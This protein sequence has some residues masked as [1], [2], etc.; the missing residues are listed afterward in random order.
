[1][2][3]FFPSILSWLPVLLT[4]LCMI[5]SA[6]GAQWNRVAY[7]DAGIAEKEPHLISGSDWRFENPGD[8]DETARTAVF[9]GRVEFGYVG[10]NPRA[11]YKVKLRFFSDG[12][13][14][15]R[16]KAGEAV[17]LDS[18]A[19]E[20]G[21]VVEREAELPPAAYAGG[22]VTL[23][24]ETVRGPNAVISAIEILST[25]SSALKAVAMP[26]APL[27]LLT[28]RPA[29]APLELSGTWKFS[30]VATEGFEKSPPPDSW[31]NIAVPG[32]WVVQGFHVKPET[33]AAYS[34]AFTLAE[35]PA[36]QRFKL[37]F[38]AVYSLC[39][40]WINGVEVGRH[41]GGFV[42]FEFDVTDAIRAG[43]NTLAVSVQS[44]SL[45]DQLSCASQY[46]CHPLGGISRKVQLFSL[47]QVHIS[48]LKIETTFGEKFRDVTLTAKLA[49][50]N[51]SASV[52]AGSATVA[53]V[54]LDVSTP[55]DAAPVAVKWDRLA[56]G[57]TLAE[58]VQ[59]AVK[60]PSKWDNEH[61]RLYKLVV[62]LRS[63]AGSDEVVEQTFGFRQIEVRG[64]RVLLNGTPIK[65][66]GV[67]RHEVHPLLGR[68]LTPELWRKDAEIF[69]E[70]NCNFIRTS[71]Y[72]P[73]EEF[74]DQCDRLGLLVELEAP[75]C[76]VGHGA[77]DHFK[78]SPSSDAIFQRL[79]L[80]NLETVQGYPN[81]PSVIMRSLA[82]ESTWSP[83]FARVHRA[84][85]KADATRPCTFHDQCWGDANNGGSRQ[86]P[87]AVIHYPGFEGP[88]RCAGE[89]RP[90]HFGEYCHLESY[91]RRELATD[92]GLRDL[93][94]QGLD[95][96]WNK[97]RTAPGCFGGSIWSAI[98]DTFFLPGGETVGYGTWGPI[99]GWRRPKPEFWHM[100]KAYSPL[101][102]RAMC[103]PIPAA[104]KPL[105]L[106]VENRHDFTDLRELQFEW[107]LGHHS[108][109]V[110]AAAAPGS[111]ATLE[112][113]LPDG[114]VKGKLLEIRAVSPRGFVEDD[115]QV[116]LGVDPRVAPPIGPSAT[117]DVDLSEGSAA[118]VI[119][120]GNCWFSVG[121][122]TGT[123]M[124]YRYPGKRSLLDGPDLLLLPA[125]DDQCGG[126][127][128][129]GPE[130]DIPFASS[131]CHDWQATSVTA[132]ATDAGVKIR[133]E[134][135]YAEAGGF[136]EMTFAKTGVVSIHYRFTVTEKGKCDPRQ[137]GL[138]FT[139]PGDCRTLS[140]RRKADWNA[141]P[142]D[143]IGRP[144][145]TAE[146]FAK[147]VPLCGFAG[148]R[149]QPTWSWS[150]DANRYGSNDFRSTKTN[151]FEAALLSADGRGVRVLSDGT[152]HV[153]A[154]VE[155]EHIRLLVAD[156]ANE[157][158]PLCFCEYTVPRRPLQ[159]GSTV[160]GTVRL[161][162]Q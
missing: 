64:N 53:I 89:S 132:R 56:P 25:D 35:K 74:L 66:H 88:S 139:L 115:W 123:L 86:M 102:L 144:Q 60:N 120:V 124:S 20:N 33:P 104:G 46:A 100:K 43:V 42:P 55:A 2:S 162:V 32:E 82:N 21:K 52:S 138:V 155:G 78:Q 12:P 5:P 73:A 4:S 6:S 76:W 119:K 113:P 1:M 110:A 148:P 57:K 62:T 85:Q 83:L 142:D 71:H 10:L 135:K 147:N 117:G 81:H 28:P 122:Y 41:E 92:P 151:V 38:S 136:Y 90:V 158:L 99:D 161:E 130:H 22:N 24:I 27:P 112:I 157:G 146:A 54:P 94:G 37:R 107:R 103:V 97:M 156:Y 49:I 29:V 129:S 68:A 26:E 19:L 140:W 8:A 127:Q 51:Q 11:A 34:R 93:W 75:L 18:V 16:V 79:A 150:R 39:R 126:M 96:M 77:S 125:S 3:P 118:Y 154:W 137:I 121:N 143:H 63:P 105:R 84:I 13:R 65:I 48:D 58:S 91:N 70:G 134:G 145:G 59:I 87:I 116:A 159:S 106:E 111:K 9:G 44:E 98:D 31:A 72:P 131:P 141:Y 80:A 133:V 160:E 45:C 153:R 114:D 69:R 101:R 152:Q 128:M 30:S 40:A 47:P 14:Q 23:A 50:R 108:G 36:G 67:C 149:T 61:P 17:L 7:D 109:K 95:A 15:E